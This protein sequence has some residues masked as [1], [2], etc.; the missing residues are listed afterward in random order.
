MSF[1]LHE[2]DIHIVC[3]GTDDVSGAG[4]A[5]AQQGQQQRGQG[6]QPGQ[7]Q[8]QGQ[9][10]GQQQQQQQTIRRV[11]PLSPERLAKPAC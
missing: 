2:R 8:Q 4:G 1:Q 10:P 5:A 11:R 9:Q 7:Q 3:R 6:Q